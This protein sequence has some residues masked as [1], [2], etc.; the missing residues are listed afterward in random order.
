[1]SSINTNTFLLI[2]LLDSSDW[3]IGF[4]RPGF[5]SEF[6]GRSVCL[7][8]RVETCAWPGKKN[9]FS[10]NFTKI[11]SK[12]IGL[13]LWRLR[14][15]SGYELQ[16]TDKKTV[17]KGWCG[18][19]LRHSCLPTLPTGADHPQATPDFFVGHTA[20][21]SMRLVHP[22]TAGTCQPHGTHMHTVLRWRFQIKDWIPRFNFQLKGKKLVWGKGSLLLRNERWT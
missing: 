10:V 12:T 21:T 8:A 6:H 1:M 22:S 15:V 13:I 20:R 2:T 3:L 11:R 16:K 5:P 19:P 14:I 7:S 9:Y 17:Y 4:V 18:F